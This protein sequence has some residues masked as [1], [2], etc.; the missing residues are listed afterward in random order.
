MLCDEDFCVNTNNI[1]EWNAQRWNAVR[2]AAIIFCKNI[3]VGVG[4]AVF[5]L[6][7]LFFYP[8]KDAGFM[9]FLALLAVCL[10]GGVGLFN[11]IRIFIRLRQGILRGPL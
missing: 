11:G 3:F 8:N 4:L 2:L 6:L 1:K 7:I 5:V 10:S 9:R